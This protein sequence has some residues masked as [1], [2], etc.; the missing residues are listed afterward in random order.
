MPIAIWEGSGRDFK[1]ATT[2]T[3]MAICESQLRVR[4]WFPYAKQNMDILGT[5]NDVLCLELWRE[6]KITD[7]K[8]W[9]KSQQWIAWRKFFQERPDVGTLIACR[10]FVRLADRFG[11][12]NAVQMWKEGHTG[13]LPGLL[14][15]MQV[16]WGRQQMLQYREHHR[17]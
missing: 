12:D 15:L 4:K 1:N 17:G 6:K 13:N 11:L 8:Y 14:Y 7:S 9:R 3:W 5:H 10:A 16:R 2:L